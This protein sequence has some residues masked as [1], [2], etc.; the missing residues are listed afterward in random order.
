MILFAR[1][2]AIAL[3]AGSA[4]WLAALGACNDANQTELSYAQDCRSP[5]GDPVKEGWSR[6]AGDRILV[7]RDGELLDLSC[8][9][10][11]DRRFPGRDYPGPEEL[12]EFMH[13][14]RAQ[15]VNCNKISQY[16]DG[17]TRIDALAYE[18]A[19]LSGDIA[20]GDP[21]PASAILEDCSQDGQQCLNQGLRSICFDCTPRCDN[22][23]LLQGCEANEAVRTSCTEQGL[24]CG[25]NGGVPACVPP[26]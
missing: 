14:C 7:C 6:C 3:A 19:V 23:V 9:E 11:L 4:L 8:P 20:V 2:M 25:E 10:D 16:C 12:D 22:G 15:N 18:E 13:V 26:Q 17:D 21:A 24:V 5:E 1:P